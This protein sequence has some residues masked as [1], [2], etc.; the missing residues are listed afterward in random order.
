M[1]NCAPSSTRAPST[2]TRAWSACRATRRWIKHHRL[3]ILGK[4]GAGKTTF[5]KH[6]ALRAIRQQTPGVPIFVS[7]KELSDSGKGIE[8]FIAHQLAVHGVPEAAGLAASLL[9]GGDALVLLDGLDEV[10]VGDEKRRVLIDALNDFIDRYT[11]CPMVMT[12]RVAASDYSFTQFRLCGD[13]RLRRRADRRATSS[14]GLPTSRSVP[15]TAARSCSARENK[16]V[17]ELAQVPLLLSM[18][19][20]T[21][22]EL[23]EFPLNRSEI[24]E[25]AMR[26]LLVKWDSS[27]NIRRDEVYKQLSLKRKQDMLAHL[28]YETFRRGDYFLEERPLV[29]QIEGYLAGV[30]GLEEPDGHVALQAMEAQHG[31]LVERAV[32]IHS[33]AHLTFQEYF[34][35][36]YIADNEARGTLDE[37]MRHVG[38]PRWDEVFLLV[39]ARL[40][41]ATEFV[42]LY[43][44][45]LDRLIASDPQLVSCLAVV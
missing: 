17:R 22:E 24:Y 21:Y 10:T 4:P 2:G 41:D 42:Q 44:A 20:L 32:R 7:L 43:R 1:P 30:P 38:D 33:F 29:R 12:C 14:S 9:E 6:T 27:R 37:L 28:A 18:L 23:G 36:S 35:A 19:C 31:I 16:P 8:E 26:A 5:L 15:R 11:E 34:A 25:E 39:A 3:F 40:P 13:G 45:A